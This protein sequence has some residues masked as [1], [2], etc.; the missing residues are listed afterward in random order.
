M[1]KYSASPAP[2]LWRDADGS[3]VSDGDIDAESWGITDEEI[4]R[5]DTEDPD[6]GCPTDAGDNESWSFG[7]VEGKLSDVTVKLEEPLS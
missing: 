7:A 1:P 3:L 5:D 6:A 2:V 4:F